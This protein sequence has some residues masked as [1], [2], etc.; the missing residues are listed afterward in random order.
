MAEDL[1]SE[2]RTTKRENIAFTLSRKD[3]G[4]SSAVTVGLRGA[5]GYGD[6]DNKYRTNIFAVLNPKK[7]FCTDIYNHLPPA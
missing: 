5:C 3:K 1:S 7:E 4:W 2:D 6:P